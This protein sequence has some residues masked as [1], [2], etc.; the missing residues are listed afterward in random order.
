[1]SPQTHPR[2]DERIRPSVGVWAAA[3]CATGFVTGFF[4]PIALNPAANQGP[5]VGLFITG[6]GG[7]IAGLV[8]GVLFRILPVTNVARVRGLFGACA[9]LALGTLW[10]CLPEPAVLGHVI[11][12]TV[13]DCARPAKLGKEALAHWQAAVARTTWA[14]PPADWPQRALANLDRDPGVVLTVNVTRRA[15][16]LQHR[17][18]WNSGDRTAGPWS[19]GA[20]PEHYYANDTG[21][22]CADY[23]ARPPQL[24][25]P[26]D[27]APASPG[28]PANPWPPVD[29]T[30]FLSLLTLGPVPAEYRRLLDAR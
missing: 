18:P 12:A 3:L 19:P 4:G 15:A 6:P 9:V 27:P 30:G 28:Q 25:L 7:A 11:D 29:T 5:L 23:V 2:S 22:S 10:F 26:S 16:I 17:K 21:V 8:L 14:H 20:G 24:Y 13:A 1:M